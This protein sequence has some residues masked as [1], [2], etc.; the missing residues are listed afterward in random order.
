MR[1]ASRSRVVSKARA[2]D[3]LR[4]VLH[5]A[6]DR[7]G[8]RYVQEDPLGFVH[9]YRASGASKVDLEIVGFYASALAYGGVKV[10]RSSLQSLFST[11]GRQPEKFVR[12]AEP[13]TAEQAFRGFVHRFHKGRDLAILTWLLRVALEKHE[14]LE[15]MFVRFDDP[16]REDVGPALAGFVGEF[17]GGNVVAF[18]SDGQ[19]PSDAPV[20][21]F[22]PSPETGSACKRL[23]LFLRWMIRRE[24]PDLG[25]W[26]S[27]DPRRLVIPLDTHVARIGRYLGLTMRL[28]G[29]WRAAQEVSAGLR[30]VAPEDP[31]RFDFPLAHLGI[32]HCLHR[33]DEEACP[34][35]P[36]HRACSMAAGLSHTNRGSG[37]A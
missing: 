7:F 15:A 28:S 11:I 3:L 25:L 8:A 26:T 1:N 27:I 2:R 10:I 4:S 12:R 9:E 30:R 37:P 14:S 34:A 31:I 18:Y 29:D 6:S 22:L 23:C 36:I 19:I 21:H 17:L 20:R 35:C 16:S 33:P 5:Q 13:E 24:E 32:H